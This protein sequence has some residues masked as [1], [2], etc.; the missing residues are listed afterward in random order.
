MNTRSIRFRSADS[1]ITV[2][3]SYHTP[4]VA[5][6]EDDNSRNRTFAVTSNKYSRTTSK[7]ITQFL[8]AKGATPSETVVSNEKELQRLC[9]ESVFVAID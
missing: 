7:H 3:F 6:I 2:F 1:S 9:E 8:Y 5:V 4:V